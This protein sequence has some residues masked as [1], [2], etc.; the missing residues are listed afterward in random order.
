[1]S[2][3][4]DRKIIPS[5]D[6]GMFESLAKRIKLILR[7]LGDARVSPLL[8][9]IPIGSLVYLLIPDLAI[10]PIDDALVIWLSTYLFVELCPP[11]V[12]QEHMKNLNQVIPGELRDVRNN[13]DDIVEGEIIDGEYTQEK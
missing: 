4:P 3:K 6:N 10:G 13:D 5:Q 2:D 9:L 11:E 1:M 12:V 8:K 7:L